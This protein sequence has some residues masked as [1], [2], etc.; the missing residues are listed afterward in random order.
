MS[1]RS[2]TSGLLSLLCLLGLT[3]LTGCANRSTRFGM[4]FISD[5]GAPDHATDIYRIPDAARDVVERLTF[6]P[7]MGEYYFLVSKNGDRIIFQADSTEMTFASSDSVMEQPHHLYLLDAAS[8]QLNDITD[9]FTVPPTT[10]PMQVVDWSPDQKQFA[11]ITYTGGLELMD[12]DGSNKKSIS[13][14]PLGEARPVM[15]GAKWSPDGKKLAVTEKDL[16]QSNLGLSGNAL[17]VY[18]LESGTSIQ[19]ASN[20]ENCGQPVWSPNS[21]QLAANCSFFDESLGGPTVMR[22]FDAENPGQP[23]Q[24]YGHLVFYPCLD[25]SWSPDGKQIAFAC[26]KNQIDFNLATPCYQNC[27]S[28]WGIF[29]TDS[30]GNGIHELKPENLDGSVSIMGPT[31]SPD[32]TQIVYVALSGDGQSRIY[33]VNLDGSNNHALTG[34]EPFY[35]I[36]AVYPVP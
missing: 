4:I 18:D 11:V 12:F 3:V 25:P 14:P 23:G 20:L 28:P 27:A 16:I 1:A 19:L 34:Q 13:V 5:N 17:L 10:S 8:R 29:I 31:W 36:V 15:T 6:T 22:I 35:T 26:R 9:L 7:K 33:S 2:V 30:D 24:P 21:Q 32:G